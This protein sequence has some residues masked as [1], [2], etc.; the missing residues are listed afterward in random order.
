MT[1]I[2]NHRPEDIA[3]NFEA[4]V[5]HVLKKIKIGRE[6]GEDGIM[7]KFLKLKETFSYNC[8]S[9]SKIRSN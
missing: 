9:S 7:I 1:I 3:E 8:N 4:D 5:H 2:V 6:A